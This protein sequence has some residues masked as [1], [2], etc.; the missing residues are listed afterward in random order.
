MTDRHLT[1]L[2][3]RTLDEHLTEAEKETLRGLYLGRNPSQGLFHPSWQRLISRDLVEWH[4]KEIR[5][6]D[7]GCRKAV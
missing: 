4:K 5:L 6:T 2:S 7:K 1:E 3:P